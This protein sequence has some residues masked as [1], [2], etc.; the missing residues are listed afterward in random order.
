M[1]RV[2]ALA[3]AAARTRRIHAERVSRKFQLE[4][5]AASSRVEKTTRRS[6]LFHRYIA[7]IH[8]FVDEVVP[9]VVQQPLSRS[10]SFLS[11]PVS[12]FLSLSIYL[13]PF[14]SLCLSLL[15]P[16]SNASNPE[17]EHC[18]TEAKAQWW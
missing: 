18:G 10:L 1:H 4:V 2:P 16:S 3:G 7:Y 13:P 8:F 11:H 12:L 17:A 5:A 6:T 9:R 15:V 14:L